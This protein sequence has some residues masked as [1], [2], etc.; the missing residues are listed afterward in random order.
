MATGES[1]GLTTITATASGVS[2]SV[3]LTV[4]QTQPQ[5]AGF[6][7]PLSQGDYWDFFW[8]YEYNSVSSPQAPVSTCPN[9]QAFTFS[10]SEQFKRGIGPVGFHSYVGHS[11]SGGGFY[12][13]FSHERTVG[14]VASSLAGADSVVP[15]APPWIQKA[16]MPLE[17]HGH[18]AAAVDG[19]IYVIGGRGYY[20]SVGS[21]YV[22]DPA[23]EW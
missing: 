20:T 15:S 13:S 17:R 5:F 4:T 3:S 11:F 19:K 23:N 7:F 12:D 1:A 14:L 18:T 6:D 21:V 9:D 2:G 16:D 10:E 22:Y 8:T